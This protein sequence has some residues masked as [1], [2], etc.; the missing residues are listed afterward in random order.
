[1]H[2]A[3]YMKIRGLK[4]TAVANKIGI[5]RATVNRI[6]RGLQR[7]DWITIILLKKWSRGAITADDFTDLRQQS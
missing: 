7:P 6:R 5:D 1:M 3:E 4:D 2:L